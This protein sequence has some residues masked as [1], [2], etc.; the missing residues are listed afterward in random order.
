MKAKGRG[1]HRILS[2]IFLFYLPL[3]L[4]GI[5]LLFPFVWMG[6]T[7][8]TPNAALYNTDRFPF[9][10]IEPTLAHYEY[11]FKKMPYL[12]WL[13]NSLIACSMSTVISLV[14]GGIAGYS[15]ARLRFYGALFIGMGIFITYL[16]PRA[17]LFLPLAYILHS[18][19]LANSVISLV[20]TYPTFLIPFCS[21]ILMGY[22]RTIPAEIEECAIIDG[23]S[24]M[25]AFVRIVVPTAVP[26]IIA[27]GVF[28]FT[29]S[30]VE[31]LYPL[32]FISSRLKKPL[33]VGIPAELLHGDVFFW[34]PLMAVSLLASIPIA[35]I[36][37]L[38]Q[39]Y[40]VSGLTAGSVKY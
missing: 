29:T 13:K 7:S 27:A 15:V 8:I 12:I 26:G 30:W 23:C 21:W 25:G 10:V 20:V 40:Y 6:F 18:W 3:F 14:I 32:S 37:A 2:K 5:F 38:L 1:D 36:Y 39:R 4:V 35:L 22:F 34:G 31:Y 17:L 16:V 11:V 33:T 28:A 24:R 9:L 19:G